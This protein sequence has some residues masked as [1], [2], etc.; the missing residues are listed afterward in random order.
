MLRSR[1]CGALVFVSEPVP[2]CRL[3]GLIQTRSTVWPGLRWSNI[4][5]SK[6]WLLLGARR[7]SWSGFEILWWVLVRDWHAV[8]LGEVAIV[9]SSV[10]SSVV[11][12]LLVLIGWKKWPL[13]V[14]W[15]LCHRIKDI[16]RGCQQK[17]CNQL[18]SLYYKIIA[19]P[20]YSKYIMFFYIYLIPQEQALCKVIVTNTHA[21][22]KADFERIAN[23]TH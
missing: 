4:L 5:R 19:I 16:S 15:I 11:S 13:G 6:L 8:E 3:E 12:A 1:W 10:L 14:H 7:A 18:F 17:N 21:T 9:L 23:L 22:T 2:G 20:W